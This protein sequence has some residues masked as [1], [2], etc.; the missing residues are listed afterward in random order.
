MKKRSILLVFSSVLL[1][2]SSLAQSYLIQVK[3]ASGKWGY[4]NV[5]GE[6]VIPAQYEHC[7]PF[8]ENGLAVVVKDKV[9]SIINAKGVVVPS[10]VSGFTVLKA[11]FGF[12]VKGYE[13][14]LLAITTPSKKFGFLDGT[15]KIAI[16]LKYDLVTEFNGGYAVAKI[17]TN[18]F[19]LD[20]KGTETA[21]T[22]AGVLE[23]KH[24][25]EGFAPVRTADK[26]Y[27]FVNPKG[28]IAIASQFNS[29]G[30][31]FGGLAWAKTA[32]GKA[33]YINTKGEWAIKPIYAGVGD[34]DPTSKVARVKEVET[35]FYIDVAGNKTAVVDTETWG[36]FSGGLAKGKK[37]E[38]FGFYNTKGEWV[39]AA[40]F[41]GVREFKNGYAAAKQGTLWGVIDT[42][43]NWVAK[44]TFAGIKDAELIK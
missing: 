5:K 27:G 15:G 38:K 41:D 28:E 11:A 14:G 7:D 42:K 29:V 23:I 34:F 22:T 6:M 20:T 25:S 4:S 3:D 33:G 13:N 2:L 8:G 18:Y 31:F 30:Y 16:P 39:I 40:Q 17:G 43:G 21:V 36:D 10:E 24:F 26:K 37:G 44:P 12:N 19:I 35:W 32:D 1:S 9:T